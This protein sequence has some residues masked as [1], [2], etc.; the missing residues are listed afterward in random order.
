MET[1]LKSQLSIADL[2]V[3]IDK[4]IFNLMHGLDGFVFGDE[5]L[6]DLRDF[7]ALSMETSVDTIL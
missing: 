6:V 3:F 7:E 4:C 5:H 1:L 2:L